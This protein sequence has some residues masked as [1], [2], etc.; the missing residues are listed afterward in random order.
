MKTKNEKNEILADSHD[1]AYGGKFLS[2]YYIL[3]SE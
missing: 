3:T 1:I 2:A